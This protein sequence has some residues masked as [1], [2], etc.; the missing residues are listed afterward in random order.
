MKNLETKREIRQRIRQKRQG[1]KEELW[2]KDSA[3]VTDCVISHPWFQEAENIYT[4]AAYHREV[5]TQEIMSAAFEMGKTVWVP[6]VAGKT[7][8][9]C[10]IESIDELK[11]GIHGILE[12]AGDERINRNESIAGGSLM[13]MPGVGFDYACHRIGYGG[14]YYDRYLEKY[15]EIRKIA[16]A[17]EFQIFPEIP[18]EE[19]DIH[20]E[21][22]ITEKRI[23]QNI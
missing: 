4:Y 5:R 3:A 17:F 6:K 16:L 8:H 18:Y 15:P 20:P 1:L 7:M 13:I 23:L 11:P 10:C 22:I 21:V 9:F 2:K 14:G 12:P 19:H